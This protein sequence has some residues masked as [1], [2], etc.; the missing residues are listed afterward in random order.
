MPPR[1][2][3]EF[4]VRKESFRWPL[5]ERV[6]FVGDTITMDFVGYTVTLKGKGMDELFD[7]ISREKVAIIRESSNPNGPSYVEKITVTDRK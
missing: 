2:T 4:G 1:V 6:V 3:F 5:S 7:Y